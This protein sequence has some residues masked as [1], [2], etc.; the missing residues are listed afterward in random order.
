MGHLSSLGLQKQNRTN[1][2]KQQ[3]Q[4]KY[5]VQGGVKTQ[6]KTLVARIMEEQCT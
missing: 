6:L 2:N 1:T 5:L 4:S 3:T